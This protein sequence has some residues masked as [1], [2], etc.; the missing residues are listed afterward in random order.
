MFR[1]G[2]ARIGSSVRAFCTDAAH[3][4]PKKLH[5]TT[6]RYAGAVYTAA[7]KA[8]VLD[9][10]ENE[11]LAFTATLDKSPNFAAYL[12]N[13]TV[14]RGEKAAMVGEVLGDKKISSITTNLFVTMS[15]NGRI[16]DAAKVANAFIELRDTAR[17]N[18]T[19]TVISA[20]PLKKQQAKEVENAVM[21]M[22]GKGKKVDLTFKEDN[23]IIGGLQIVIGDKVLDLSIAARVTE[24]NMALET[25]GDA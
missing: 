21:A 1:G 7:S 25:A 14:P 10:V 11:L 17:G 18:V 4:P 6:G 9:K 2:V 20:E 22:I 8:G 24:L 5:G 15:A 12:A 3:A 13:P 23:N 19:A 16:A